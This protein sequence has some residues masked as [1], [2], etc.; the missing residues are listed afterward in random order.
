VNPSIFFEGMGFVFYLNGLERNSSK[1]LGLKE[2]VG[3]IKARYS[4]V[5]V[6]DAQDDRAKGMRKSI[7]RIPDEVLKEIFPIKRKRY[8]T[9]ETVYTQLK[10]MILSGK[11]EKGER[12]MQHYRS[13]PA[14]ID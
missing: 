8:Q 9:P 6:V 1:R 2:N 11:L 13:S 7:D 3:S 12:L 10:Q 5:P 14:S 4:R